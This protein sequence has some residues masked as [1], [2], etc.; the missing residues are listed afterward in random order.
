MLNDED[1]YNPAFVKSVFDRCSSRYILFSYFFSFGFTER[2]RRQCVTA[3]TRPPT[4][5]AKGYDLMAGTGEVW[6]QL[7]KQFDNIHSVI[8]V[9]I[10]TGMHEKAMLRLH[11]HRNHKIQF[12][13]DDILKSKLPKNSADFVISTFGLKTF[14]FA[15]QAKLAKLVSQTLKPGGVFSLIEASDPKGWWLR[16]FYRFHLMVLLPIIERIF[17]QGAKDFAMIGKYTDNFGDITQFAKLLHEE[18]L[19]VNQTKFFFGCATGV[20]G[21]KPLNHPNR[22]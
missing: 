17:L 10:S 6:P 4:P 12:V 19:E 20:S 5:D 9:D 21:K 15:Q 14:S 22:P 1:I 7:F 8:A 3:L 11:K 16:P 18:G 2:W 13:E